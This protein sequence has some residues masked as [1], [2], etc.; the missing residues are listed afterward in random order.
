MACPGS[1]R[2]PPYRPHYHRRSVLQRRGAFAVRQ[3]ER[4]NI[5]DYKMPSDTDDTASITRAIARAVALGTPQNLYLPCGTY[6][7]SGPITLTTTAGTNQGIVVQGQSA[8]CVIVRQNADADGFDITL[9]NYNNGIFQGSAATISG[10]TLVMQDNASTTRTAISLASASG[11]GGN[12]HP[13]Q[14]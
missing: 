4:L 2:L 5:A 1:M 7:I 11:N 3:G 9:N 12:R 14:T 13:D 10:I 8:A 6:N